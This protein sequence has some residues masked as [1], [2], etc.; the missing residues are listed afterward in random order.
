[1]PPMP[2]PLVG[3]SSACRN[4]LRIDLSAAASSDIDVMVIGNVT[5]GDV[6]KALHPA[7]AALGREINPKIFRAIEWRKRVAARDPFVT[8]VLAKPK[9]FLVG[10]ADELAELGRRKP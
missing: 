10:N 3:D 8:D 1:M 9:L 6:V 7:Q 5:F 4:R 2:E